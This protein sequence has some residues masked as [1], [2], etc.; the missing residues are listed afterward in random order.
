MEPRAG[1]DPAP[2]ASSASGALSLSPL[3]DSP[4]PRH[5]AGRDLAET[6]LS[7]V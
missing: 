3:V 5:L 7:A 1:Q 4:S 2:M 6:L